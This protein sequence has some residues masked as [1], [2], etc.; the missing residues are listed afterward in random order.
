MPTDQIICLTLL[1]K[2]VK[3]SYLKQPIHFSWEIW[4]WT[5]LALLNIEWYSSSQPY[6]EVIAH[7]QKKK[8]RL[9]INNKTF[10]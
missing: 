1:I 7:K 2:L 6:T 5:S 9:Q 4:L 8:S 3:T 10:K